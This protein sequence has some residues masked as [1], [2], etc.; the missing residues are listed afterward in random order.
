MRSV[1]GISFTSHR[2]YQQITDSIGH[3]IFYQDGGYDMT[4][5]GRTPDIKEAEYVIEF[6]TNAILQ[7]ESLVGDIN[8][9]FEL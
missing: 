6:A 1:V 4:S 9:P 7:I 5:K 2:R 3:V 8:K